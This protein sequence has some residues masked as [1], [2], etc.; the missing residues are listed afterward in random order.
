MESRVIKQSMSRKQDKGKKDEKKRGGGQRPNTSCT[1]IHGKHVRNP[2]WKTR[3]WGKK[4]LWELRN[5]KWIGLLYSVILLRVC[6]G[7]DVLDAGYIWNLLLTETRK[8]GAKGSCVPVTVEAHISGPVVFNPIRSRTPRCN[9]CSTLYPWS[10][11]S[12]IQVTQ[13]IIYI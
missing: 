9:F 4:L 1:R 8:E 10:W 11:W 6:T 3:Q 13:S 5:R 2:I 12:I 7:S